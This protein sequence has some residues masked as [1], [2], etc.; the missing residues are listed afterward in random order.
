MLVDYHINFSWIVLCQP[1][2][3][4][5]KL[6]ANE[7]LPGN[8]WRSHWRHLVKNLEMKLR[9]SGVNFINWNILFDIISTCLRKHMLLSSLLFKLVKNLI[10][11][12]PILAKRP[13]APLIVII[14]LP[15]LSKSMACTGS[16]TN[17]YAIVTT[18]VSLVLQ[19]RTCWCFFGLSISGLLVRT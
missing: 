11:V 9:I 4:K 19:T 7:P 16:S 12:L 8:I 18:F 17:W 15:I 14:I 5:S 10:K 3:T 6:G 1:T 2:V 13:G